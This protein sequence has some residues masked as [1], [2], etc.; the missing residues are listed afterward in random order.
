MMARG[1]AKQACRFEFNVITPQKVDADCR[2]GTV[3]P[4]ASALFS[5]TISAAPG[6]S[7]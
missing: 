2:K 1:I 3:V 5:A 4:A 7:L 6:F